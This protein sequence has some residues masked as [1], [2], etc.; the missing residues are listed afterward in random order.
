LLGGMYP[1]SRWRATQGGPCDAS[2]AMEGLTLR[3][4]PRYGRGH[5]ARQA[6]LWKGSPCEASRAMEGLALRGKPRQGRARPA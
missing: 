1:A 5:P 4:K 2:R 6:A 3:D